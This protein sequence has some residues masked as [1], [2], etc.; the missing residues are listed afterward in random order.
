M[1]RQI[2]W[3]KLKTRLQELRWV[4][5]VNESDLRIELVNGS[6]IA[7]RGAD[8]F[9]SLRGVGLD[10]LVLDEVADIDERAFTEVLRP[11]L[12]DRQ[13]K[14]LFLGTPKGRG[15]WLFDL[16]QRGQD[17]TEHQWESWQ[18]TTEQ[19][20]QVTRDEIE[21]AR[22]DLD[23]RTYEQE[24]Q[25]SFVTH[26]GVIYYNFDRTR[27]VREYQDEVPSHILVGLDFNVN[28]VS[29][30]V[31]ARTERGLHIFDEILIY[32][33]NTDELVDE[34]KNRYPNNRV[35]VFPDPAGS[36]RKTSSAGRTDITILENAGFAVKYHRSHPP[37][38]DRINAV[39]SLLLNAASET[40][41]LIDPRCRTYI[42]C[43]E[44]Q[45]YKE[46]TQIP[47]KDSGFD[48][49]NDAAGYLCEYLFPI[50]KDREEAD[51]GTW[52]V[53]TRTKRT[54]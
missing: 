40:R 6:V 2:V 23:A 10:F 42:E 22:R 33:S 24:F 15:N 39:N 16:Y 26:S 45:T 13:G 21:A 27:N 7:L 3:D 49:L 38:R 54:F 53:T 50:R 30:V 20:G 9:D 51:L 31:A 18:Y 52:S 12:A 19:G 29:A 28:P 32:G 48:H 8:N 4:R 41:L 47:D 46:G 14:A 17:P 1:S 34:L 5:K 43:L 35:T 25:A 36:A 11:T 44:K 37:V